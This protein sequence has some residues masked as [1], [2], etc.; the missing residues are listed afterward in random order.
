MTKKTVAVITGGSTGIGA[1]TARLFGSR[2][3]AVAILDVNRER[4]EMTASAISAAGGSARFYACDV[5][6]AKAVDAAAAS[7][8]TD[9]GLA[10]ILVT[11]AGLIPNPE[12][13]MDMDLEAHD[14]MWQV[15]Y[16]GTIHAC[17]SFG[18]QMIRQK[19]GAIV[20]LGSINSLAPMPLPA[21]NPGKLAIARLTQL[22]AVEL[23][24]H[25]IRVNSVGPTYVMTETLQARV[26]AGLRDLKKIM[27]VH[28][29]DTLPGP[30]DI[31]LAIGF[32]C[33]SEARTITGIL[34]PIDAGWH[35][36][37]SYK[38]YAGGVPWKD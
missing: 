13:V 15:N 18:R 30:D 22:L 1:A 17:R 31:A 12:S 16:H 24:R 23:G 6:D 28:A 8:E 33:S 19:R 14:R 35:A 36:S 10:E 26:D 38:T 3:H 34:L 25:G 37:V 9:L 29:L 32:L 21:Y 20:T 5:A 11:S 7:V 2:G 4:G 27:A